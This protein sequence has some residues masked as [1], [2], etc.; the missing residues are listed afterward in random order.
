MTKF[1]RDNKEQLSICFMKPHEPVSSIT[2]SKW[3]V[4]YKRSETTSKCKTAGLS[5]KWISKFAGWSSERTFALF[6]E[7]IIEENFQ[8][9]Q[10]EAL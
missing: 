3:W 5:F 9:K 2:L 4:N 8:S 10:Y 7:K 1:L 6:Y